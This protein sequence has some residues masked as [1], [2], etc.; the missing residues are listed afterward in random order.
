M[1][2]RHASS[3]YS[4]HGNASN[5]VDTTVDDDLS[6]RH[7]RSSKINSIGSSNSQERAKSN[8]KNSGIPSRRASNLNSNSIPS[9]RVSISKHGIAPHGA[10]R[11][12]AASSKI[13]M[14]GTTSS[15]SQ[16]LLADITTSRTRIAK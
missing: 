9:H 14:I 13:N 11:H 6:R 15:C 16:D 3:N 5:G 7:A 12:L 4:N 2:S 1:A 8:S 10:G